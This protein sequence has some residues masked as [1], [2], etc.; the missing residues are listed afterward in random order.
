[1]FQRTECFVG[2]PVDGQDEVVFEENVTHNGEEIDEDKSQHGRE[3]DGAAVA[4]DA[5]YHVQQGLF[6]VH[7]IK[8]LEREI[9]V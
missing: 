7:Q 9:F 1:M 8:E 4:G 6:S 2:Y 5:F 3:D